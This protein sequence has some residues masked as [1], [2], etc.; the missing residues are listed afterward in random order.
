MKRYIRGSKYT[1]QEDVVLD[2]KIIIDIEFDVPFDVNSSDQVPTKFP[3]VDQF[4]KDVIA[5]LENEFHFEVIEDIYDGVRQKG[6]ITNRTDSI[7]LY[8]DTYFD[9]SNADSVLSELGIHND[10]AIDKGK[11]YCFVHLRFSDHELNDEGDSS[12]R[13]F[14]TENANRYNKREVTHVIK[15]E[16]IDVPERV[17]YQQYNQ[18]L[19]DLE[20]ELKVRISMWIHK[21]DRYRKLDI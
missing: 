14:L 19:A 5:L 6:H 4:K 9:L 2:D 18:A 8:F 17:M 16:S 20:Y 11:V 3:G 15:E 10:V 21:L 7:S 12:H 13:K 1:Q